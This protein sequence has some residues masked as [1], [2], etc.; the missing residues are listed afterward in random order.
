M[1]YDVLDFRGG[2]STD[3]FAN[4]STILDMTSMISKDSPGSAHQ[5][6]LP[7]AIDSAKQTL[8]WVEEGKEYYYA[9]GCHAAMVKKE[10]GSLYYLELQSPISSNN[11]WQ[12]LDDS[13]LT[14][15]FGCYYTNPRD[16]MLSVLIDSQAFNNDNFVSL[17][18]YINTDKNRQRK[19]GG[20]S[21]K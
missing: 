11:G 4:I 17:L 5:S 2:A 13:S 15:R 20:G 19:G 3:L 14:W 7:K 9:A 16:G 1:G 21:V 10:G 18:G 6:R 12:V 8:E